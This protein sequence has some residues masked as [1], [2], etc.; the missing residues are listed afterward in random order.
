MSFVIVSRA[1]VLPLTVVG[2]T[3]QAKHAFQVMNSVGKQNRDIQQKIGAPAPFD[4]PETSWPAVSSSAEAAACGFVGQGRSS[5]SRPS[6]G[7]GRNS[8]AAAAD[9]QREGGTS[10]VQHPVG[11]QNYAEAQAE[12]VRNKARMRG[13]QD[14]FSGYLTADT[15]PP[16]M[17]ARRHGSLPPPRPG[18]NQVNPEALL[19]QAQ[20][21]VAFE[22]GTAKGISADKIEYLNSK[23]LAESNRDR[24]ELR[25]LAGLL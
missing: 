1:S 18:Q 21:K 24:N 14:L 16:G 23:V 25:S 11:M 20:M 4:A 15:Q 8:S 9:T 22:G 7:C 10:P 17:R 13:S 5:G 12:A 3:T 2:R 19:P 6:S